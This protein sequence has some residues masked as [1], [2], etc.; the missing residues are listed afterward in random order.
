LHRITSVT[1]ALGIF[2]ISIAT[3]V[4][5]FNVVFI[6]DVVVFVAFVAIAIDVFIFNVFIFNVITIN[7]IIHKLNLGVVTRY[8][9]L[10]VAPESLGP[11]RIL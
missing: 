6:F 1:I 3:V 9:P 7:V 11:R 2:D 8:A 10:D 4:F 5:V